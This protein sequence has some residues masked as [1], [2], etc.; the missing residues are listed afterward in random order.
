MV[1]F[2]EPPFEKRHRER[3][4]DQP[5]NRTF[6]GTRA[7]GG[8]IPDLRDAAARRV[9]D[10]DLD[11]PIRERLSYALELQPDDLLEMLP[12]QGPEDENLVDAVQE[13]GL[14]LTSQ[15]LADVVLD[16]TPIPPR[17]P[18]ARGSA[19]FRCCSS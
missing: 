11:L 1:A 6:Q 14:E 16:S 13:L 7:K 17:P 19:R 8:L 9:R 12:G 15:G 2:V 4:R 10:V 3:I 5:L 18:T